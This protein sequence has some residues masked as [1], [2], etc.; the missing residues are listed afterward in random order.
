MSAGSGKL[1]AADES[2]VVAESIFDP[3]VVEGCESNGRLS[4]APCADESDGLEV[5]S[6]S[7]DLLNQL[8]T[9]ETVPRRRGR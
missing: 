9:S 8:V 3:I 6:E 2:A 1:I 7:D 4:D 5:F